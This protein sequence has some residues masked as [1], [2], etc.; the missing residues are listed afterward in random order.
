MVIEV[1]RSIGRGGTGSYVGHTE[2]IWCANCNDLCQAL[3]SCDYALGRGLLVGHDLR[4]H[5]V[6]SGISE[7]QLAAALDTVDTIALAVGIWTTAG[8]E[9]PDWQLP[10]STSA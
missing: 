2:G 6:P 5:P 4:H 7:G 9:P 10:P 8:P 3:P 1:S